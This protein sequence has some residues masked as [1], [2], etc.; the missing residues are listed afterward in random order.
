VL[1][2]YGPSTGGHTRTGKAAAPKSEKLAPIP[3]V[4]PVVACGTAHVRFSI[5]G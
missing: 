3:S 1:K 5:L 4:E 2:L